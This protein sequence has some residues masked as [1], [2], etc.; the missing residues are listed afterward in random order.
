MKLFKSQMLHE[1]AM[2]AIAMRR[3]GYA[4]RYGRR[5]RNRPCLTLETPRLL[6]WGHEQMALR[7]PANADI[8]RVA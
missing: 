8:H 2:P 7:E 5:Q 4:P 3:S 1:P 6:H